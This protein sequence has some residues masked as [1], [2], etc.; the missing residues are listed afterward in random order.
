MISWYKNILKKPQKEI[1]IWE[2]NLKKDLFLVL[3]NILNFDQKNILILKRQ[4]RRFID[5]KLSNL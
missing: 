3:N 2:K 1:K 4:T 5:E